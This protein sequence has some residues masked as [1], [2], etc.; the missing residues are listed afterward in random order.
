MNVR[1]CVGESE[2][3]NVRMCVCREAASLFSLLSSLLTSLSSSLF[4]H[5]PSLYSLLSSHFTLLTPHFSLVTPHF[6]LLS[7]HSSLV[8]PLF[9]FLVRRRA[10]FR[11]GGVCVCV[12][13]WVGE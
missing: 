8:A 5:L 12:C 9:H 6:S 3:V 2:W 13:G 1:V 7:S 11:W 4:S 10:R